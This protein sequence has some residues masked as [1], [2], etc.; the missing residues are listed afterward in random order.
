MLVNNFTAYDLLMSDRVPD[1]LRLYYPFKGNSHHL[2]HDDI[3]T[4][5][6]D[7]KIN[8]NNE[9]NSDEFFDNVGDNDVNNHNH[10]TSSSSSNYSISQTSNSKSSENSVI[11]CTNCPYTYKEIMDQSLLP[12]PGK[13]DFSAD[14]DKILLHIT[15]S[16]QFISKI[17]MKGGRKK[18]WKAV[19]NQFSYQCKLAKLIDPNKQI[20][21]RS[22]PQQL[23]NRFIRLQKK[24]KCP[25]RQT[26]SIEGLFPKNLS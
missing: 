21:D 4:F 11:Q 18:D 25:V 24:N 12:P 15:T 20:Y 16:D 23:E 13:G 7:W 2:L 8:S 1:Y 5:K 3:T 26:S 19:L 22:I 9:I 6:Q 10:I 17:T 14:E